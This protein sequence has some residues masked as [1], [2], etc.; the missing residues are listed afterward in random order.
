[1]NYLP[2]S[3]NRSRIKRESEFGS[4]I[5][6]HRILII[7][8]HPLTR[9]G[10]KS[11]I[12]QEMGFKIVGEADSGGNGLKM[13]KDLKPDI[14]VLD[15][16]LPDTSGVRLAPKIKA[17]TPDV[18]I[19]FVSMYAKIDYIS[20]ALAAGGIGYVIKG[21]A[22]DVFSKGL[23]TV[24]GGGYFLDPSLSQEIVFDLIRRQKL[25]NGAIADTY[26]VLTLREQEVLRL[27]T[28]GRTAKQIAQ[29]LFIS[30]K[31][32]QNHRYNIMQK[33]DL[34]SDIDLIKYAARIGL[35]DTDDWKE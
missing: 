31:T 29:K 35:I 14:I 26:S 2:R 22:A 12:G 6:M 11:V 15:I 32:A 16:A 9:E 17:V 5:P 8:D 7:E 1:M 28:D 33:L 13:V 19:L 20:E 34:H 25:Q 24:A 23:R 4:T 10:L 27:L 30:A 3:Q 21:S 18:R